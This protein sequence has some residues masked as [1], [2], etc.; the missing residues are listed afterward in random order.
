[1]TSRVL[2]TDSDRE[3]FKRLLDSQK[4]PCTVT[5]VKGK[6][7]TPE[8]NRTQFMWF[9]EIDEQLPGESANYWRG[10][11]KLRF[12]VPILRRD[13]P[14]FC[15]KYDR[16]IKPLPYEDKIELMMEPMDFPITRL[17]STAQMS[18]YED[19][20]FRHFADQGVVLTVPGIENA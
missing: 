12:G 3:Q 15:E 4:L 9:E 19:A 6:K 14:E 8:Q 10:Y 5:V 20:L 18:E 1:M 13:N 16:I 11:C 7:R 17:M 2:F